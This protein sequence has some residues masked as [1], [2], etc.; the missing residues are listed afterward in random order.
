M[1]SLRHRLLGL[2][3]LGAGL[4]SLTAAGATWYWAQ[5]EMSEVLDY[6]L[7]QQALSLADKAY[8]L[9]SIAV[10]EPDPEQHIVTQL[11]DRRGQLRYQSHQGV[12]LARPERYGYASVRGGDRDWRVYATEIGPWVVQLAQPLAIRADI[13]TT[14]ALRMLYPTLAVLPLLALL[15]WWAVGRVLAPL[16][17]LARTVA[18]REPAALEPLPSAGLPEEV[19]LLATALNDLV[20]RQHELL[21]RQQDFMADAAHELRTPLTALRLQLQLLERAPDDAGRAQSLAELRRGIERASLLIERL[22]SVARLDAD[23]GIASLPVDLA[24]VLRKAG[25]EVAPLAQVR[26][27]TL[28]LLATERADVAGDERS[29]LALVVNLLENALCHGASPGRVHAAV[30]VV[31]RG[32]RLVVMDNGPGIAPAERAR[33]FERFHRA[34]GTTQPG[35][36]LGL[37]IV[38][39]VA[40]L[41]GATVRIDDA[42][43]GGA[44]V[45]VDFPAAAVDTP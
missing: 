9:G 16:S 26:H 42:P 7:R 25:A 5:R 45:E 39:R 38:R 14:A 1:T 44:L 8:L 10:V 19:G 20:A 29:L 35:S 27:A 4:V 13:A 40:D 12:M 43:G 15:I 11:W 6:Q 31:R 2:L 33:V 41:H 17:A 3:L 30:E 21:A 24:E 34:A 18:V 23:A 37:A 28:E 22:L 32:V 36:G